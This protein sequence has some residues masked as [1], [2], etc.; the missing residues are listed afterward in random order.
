MNSETRD[1]LNK[2]VRGELDELSTRKK[3]SE[4]LEKYT[5]LALWNVTN[6]D[7][8]E[9]DFVVIK[10]SYDEDYQNSELL[11][12]KRSDVAEVKK[13]IVSAHEEFFGKWEDEQVRDFKERYGDFH[14]YLEKCLDNHSNIPHVW[15][16]YQDLNFELF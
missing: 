1:Y 15:L 3:A 16:N 9:K 10:I 12:V 11:L 6:Q 14:N 2:I 7:H 13:Y 8:I 5:M 4:I